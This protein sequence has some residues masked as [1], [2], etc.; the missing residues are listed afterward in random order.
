MFVLYTDPGHTVKW[1]GSGSF[2]IY[3]YNIGYYTGGLAPAEILPDYSTTKVNITK[4]NAT[5]DYNKF[6]VP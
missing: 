2:W 5:V 4:A 3:E 6:M 1:N